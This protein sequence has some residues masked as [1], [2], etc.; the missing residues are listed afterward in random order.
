MK[1]GVYNLWLSIISV[2]MVAV[3]VIGILVCVEKPEESEVS[4]N[5]TEQALK[6]E[7]V[8]LIDT[9]V[10]EDYSSVLGTMAKLRNEYSETLKIFTLGYTVTGKT[11]P[12]FTMG[13][14]E[15]TAL[16]VGGLHAR[17]HVTTKFLLRCIEDYCYALEKGDGTFDGYNLK[18][19]FSEYTV[20]IVP[21]L[22]VDGLEIVLSNL[23]VK[24]G[25]GIDELS[26]Y[27]C[28]YNGVDLNRNFPL[29]WD[30]I[31]NG[32]TEPFGYFFRGYE[33]A[34][35]NETKAIMELCKNHQFSFM[36]SIH[37]K[38]NCI[39]WADTY[40]T[41]FN[42]MYEAFTRDIA[43]A[44][45]MVMLEPTL[46]ATGYGGGF[47][48]WFRHTHSKPGLCVEL[49]SVEETIKPCGAENYKDFNSFVNYEKT[50]YI[51]AAALNSENV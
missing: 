10:P 18:E 45:D 21:C 12:M 48:N 29:A 41:E 15:K 6:E 5:M 20:Y 2:T 39:Y 16:V 24:K 28:N 43:T 34:S 30:K 38:G 37:A 51:L 7:F 23:P 46:K 35:E 50:K 19:L 13:N 17:E 25:V 33:P 3:L 49:V 8:S 31:D 1:N 22:N 9:T 47:E 40:K 27:K 26:E 32:V 4:K 36:L 11:I 14:G 42:S 44:A